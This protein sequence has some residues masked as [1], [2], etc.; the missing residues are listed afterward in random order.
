M[1]YTWLFLITIYITSIKIII[2]IIVNFLI[3]YEIISVFVFANSFYLNNKL[4]YF[5]YYISLH[6]Y[7]FRFFSLISINNFLNYKN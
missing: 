2:A 6:I 4:T 5:K 3:I 1:I 7:Y